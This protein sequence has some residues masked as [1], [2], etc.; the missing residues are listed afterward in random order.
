MDYVEWCREQYKL[1][2]IPEYYRQRSK[3]RPRQYDIW[4]YEEY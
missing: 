3:F 1:E 2:C 4:G